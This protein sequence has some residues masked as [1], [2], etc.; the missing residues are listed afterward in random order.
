M[1]TGGLARLAPMEEFFGGSCRVQHVGPPRQRNGGKKMVRALATQDSQN[2]QPV[3][4]E[5]PP[6]TQL[7]EIVIPA[8]DIVQRVGQDEDGSYVITTEAASKFDLTTSQ[9]RP[10]KKEASPAAAAAAAVSMVPLPVVPMRSVT[11]PP[12]FARPVSPPP[13]PAMS[14]VPPPVAASYTVA[15]PAPKVMRPLSQPPPSHVLV[16]H[17]P[18]PQRPVTPP[19]AAQYVRPPI[20]QP[21]QAVP[22]VP[23]F[24]PQPPVL[25]QPQTYFAAPSPASTPST[26]PPPKRVIHYREA[27]PHPLS[28]PPSLLMVPKVKAPPPQMQMAVGAPAP[29]PPPVVVHHPPVRTMPLPATVPAPAP[30]LEGPLPLRVA[31]MLDI[32]DRDIAT[33]MQQTHQMNVC[34]Q[35]VEV[36]YGQM[37][38]RGVDPRLAH[39]AL[40]AAQQCANTLARIAQ[41]LRKAQQLLHEWTSELQAKDADTRRRM[42][43]DLERRCGKA[44]DTLIATCE[45]ESRASNGRRERPP[46]KEDSP[47]FWSLRRVQDEVEKLKNIIIAIIR[48][49]V[50]GIHAP[51][52]VT[53]PL[54]PRQVISAPEDSR[55]QQELAARLRTVGNELK[56]ASDQL[57]Q[58][59]KKDKEL[60][61]TLQHERKTHEAELARLGNELREAR[62]KTP[63]KSQIAGGDQEI[64]RRLQQE[65]D[66]YADEVSRLQVD[67]HYLKKQKPDDSDRRRLERKA[68]DL[69]RER[70][71][72]QEHVMK[73]QAQFS[74][75]PGLQN[76]VNG[77]RRLNTDLMD[78]NK[79][80]QA[81]ITRLRS[82]VTGGEKRGGIRPI[83]RLDEMG[84]EILSEVKGGRKSA[85]LRDED[86]AEKIRTLLKEVEELKKQASAMER[87]RVSIQAERD[88]G[89]GDKARLE[90]EL[91]NQLQVNEELM[92]DRNKIRKELAELKAKAKAQRVG[93]GSF[94]S[95]GSDNIFAEPDD[96]LKPLKAENEGLRIANA[97]LRAERDKQDAALRALRDEREGLEQ[98][99]AMERTR[100]A[101][102]MHRR[103]DDLLDQ[104]AQKDADIAAKEE[105]LAARDEELA[106]KQRALAAKQREIEDLKAQLNELP[107]VHENLQQLR[108][109]FEQVRAASATGAREAADA[110]KRLREAQ[111]NLQNAEDK[112]S[113]LQRQLDEF[114]RDREKEILR[115]EID[116]LRR[117][118]RD[119]TADSERKAEECLKKDREIDKRL[120]RIKELEDE[121]DDLKERLRGLRNLRALKTASDVEADF[122]RRGS[123]RSVQEMGLEITSLAGE[124]ERLKEQKA[125]V[126]AQRDRLQRALEKATQEGD[127]LRE[128][129]AGLDSRIR[130]LKKDKKKLAEAL[131]L[132]EERLQ[133]LT[134]E[135]E[136]KADMMRELE[137]SSLR[138]LQT[139]FEVENDR[140]EKEL[141]RRTTELDRKDV[142]ILGLEDEIDRL[143]KKLKEAEEEGRVPASELDNANK[144]VEDLKR[145]VQQ[146][147]RERDAAAAAAAAGLGGDADA[148]A[149]ARK[150]IEDL[151]QAWDD[152]NREKEQLA[153]EVQRLQRELEDSNGQT[154][155][156]MLVRDEAIKTARELEG[157]LQ[158]V[159]K[160]TLKEG[161]LIKKL[162]EAADKINDLEKE[163]KRAEELGGQV[164]QLRDEL[165]RQKDLSRRNTKELEKIVQNLQDAQQEFFEGRTD[166]GDEI[167][168]L[169]DK[170]KAAV[171][172]MADYEGK[173]DRAQDLMRQMR[174]LEQQIEDLPKPPTEVGDVVASRGGGAPRDSYVTAAEGGPSR[175]ASVAPPAGRP[176]RGK[177]FVDEAGDTSTM[178]ILLAPGEDDQLTQPFHPDELAAFRKYAWKPRG[179]ELPDLEKV[180]LTPEQAKTITAQ[181]AFFIKLD[182]Q[183]D[184]KYTT[185]KRRWF[186]LD[187]SNPNVFLTYYE[188]QFDPAKE[189]PTPLGNIPETD[190]RDAFY[191]GKKLKISLG[192]EDSDK[193]LE[194]VPAKYFLS[195][196]LC[197]REIEM[198]KILKRN[199]R[200]GVSA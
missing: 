119:L 159:G 96:L 106:T 143:K 65:R 129:N 123:D 60:E 95:Q 181:G 71:Q 157:L 63:P 142:I 184:T 89:V 50:G 25:I 1:Q 20:A 196:I 110:N 150:Q 147:E 43:E 32:L 189:E 56:R 113:D 49:S 192:S 135:E 179:R 199:R 27:S 31:S 139:D 14:Y 79:K 34:T 183:W 190:L 8:S 122:L 16:P 41:N 42:A 138:R 151:R 4:L 26:P 107:V 85:R 29:S 165:G 6:D 76:E 137:V 67:L 92:A 64:V 97:E 80:Q 124:I 185:T 93:R 30:V 160:H 186:V 15:P 177:S 38:G 172:A 73:M 156:A 149:A 72:L 145:R 191:D 59:R 121:L 144:Q 17:Q 74:K 46:P 66:Q 48:S 3:R 180:Q 100:G 33:F 171:K 152:E 44:L 117:I 126:A 188:N 167:R 91:A 111:Q 78:T 103:M 174:Q 182:S 58:S 54:P 7:H 90:R 53:A 133:G 125:E 153:K 88:A 52:T 194:R 40:Q 13:P 175:A 161:E 170:L 10:P 168:N 104:L 22:V 12:V 24:A 94:A 45:K 81:E 120:A 19:P 162:E 169:M 83:S 70:D 128:S 163:A 102:D 75:G 127:D 148:L 87:V 36:Q 197:V 109:E 154:D 82:E 77:L 146:L 62:S 114:D 23:K 116:A 140:K 118:N 166:Y 200:G 187:F 173:S 39:Q 101:D 134:G 84:P 98:S 158:E 130:A 198:L 164:Q 193:M 51:V 21:I 112:I 57:E 195:L 105:E 141:G 178:E 55:L 28:P 115:N 86:M 69:Q 11:P 99:L 61:R 176:L 37:H 47:G 108:G 132:A 155:A 9:G 131:R 2:R 18:V 68:N 35:T 5:F 136:E